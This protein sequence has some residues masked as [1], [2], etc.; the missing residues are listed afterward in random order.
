MNTRVERRVGALGGVGRQGTCNQRRL[1]EHLGLEQASEGIGGRELRAIE[2]G[3]AFLGAQRNRFQ[4]MRRKGDPGRHAAMRGEAFADTDHHRGHVRQG[5]KIA[6]SA[7]GTLCRHDRNDVVSQHL[8]QQVDGLLPHARG[9]LRQA[10]HLE[11]HHQAR[12][13]NRHRFANA[14]GMRQHDVALQRFEIGG[15]N[16]HAGELTETG[17]DAVDRLALGDDAFDRLGA[18][19]DRS[20]AGRV[21]RRRGATIDGTPVSQRGI[22]GLQ[23]EFCHCPLQ[24]R[25]WSGLKPMR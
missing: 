25:A 11:R 3:Q 23:Y 16:A 24:I 13:S 19:L 4:P 12:Y 20:L 18:G 17:I 1:I 22:A 7:D 14:G 8:L 15:G 21:E 5:G 6:G 10:R 2:Q 9:A